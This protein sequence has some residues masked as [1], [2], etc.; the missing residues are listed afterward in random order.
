MIKTKSIKSWELNTS[1]FIV[2]G[3]NIISDV[4]T[5]L[6]NPELQYI[7]VTPSL[8]NQIH[9]GLAKKLGTGKLKCPSDKN[10]CYIKDQ[11]INV[12]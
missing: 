4:E 6:F 1:R 3:T 12:D 7:Y 10:F 8:W 9:N 5:T 2:G 11:C